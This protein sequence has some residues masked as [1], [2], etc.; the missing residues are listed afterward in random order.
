ML[1]SLSS[2]CSCLVDRW[3][4]YS[5]PQ[6]FL[7]GRED[8]LRISFDLT[9]LDKIKHLPQHAIRARRPWIT[10]TF[11][12]VVRFV[13]AGWGPTGDTPMD[14]RVKGE[15]WDLA[16]GTIIAVSVFSGMGFIIASVI[17]H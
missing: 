14:D 2:C 4:S 8:R 13:A 11:E 10:E 7:D 6:I 9:C 16:A 1:L 12:R 17:I 3:H 15:I 5:C